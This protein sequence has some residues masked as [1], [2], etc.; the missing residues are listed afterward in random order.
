MFNIKKSKSDRAAMISYMKTA[1]AVTEPEFCGIMQW[2]TGLKPA[3]I[4]IQL[5]VCLDVLDFLHRLL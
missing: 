2:A 1:T 4:K 3:C 5:P